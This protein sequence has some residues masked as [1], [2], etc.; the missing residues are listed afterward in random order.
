MDLQSPGRANIH[1]LFAANTKFFVIPK[2]DF[3]GDAF[4]IVT[5][6]A[7]KRATLEEYGCTDTWTVVHGKALNIKNSSPH[8]RLLSKSR[9][10]DD[11]FLKIFGQFSKIGCVPGNPHCQTSIDL[12]ILLCI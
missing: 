10:R 8:N 1:T 5:P 2:F 6:A 7:G 9:A 12:R 11:L 4:G 3:G